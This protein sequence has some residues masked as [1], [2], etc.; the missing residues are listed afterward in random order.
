ME[1]PRIPVRKDFSD[2]LIEI[3]GACFSVI[4]I[5]LPIYYYSELP[6]IIPS[7]FNAAGEPD[8]YNEKSVIWTL[9]IMGLIT[10][11]GLLFLNQ[12]PHIFN[13]PTPITEQN[14][15]HQYRIATKLI[16]TLNM[17]IVVGFS[18]ISYS[19]IQAAFEQQIGLGTLFLP[20][21]LLSIFGVVGFYLYTAFKRR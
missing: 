9:P 12:Y 18:Y 16:R 11:L 7:H 14:A 6:D 21:F 10:Y 1:R 17:V 15:E 4:M 20:L 2:W 8:D 19:T 13:Y 5:G 3:I